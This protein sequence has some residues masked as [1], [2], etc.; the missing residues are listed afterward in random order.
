MTNLSTL[1]GKVAL[2]TGGASVIGE[3]AAEV[4]A[5]HG[6]KVAGSDIQDELGHS[7]AKALGPS[8]SSYVHCAVTD[9]AQVRNAVSTA[10]RTYEAHVSGLNLFKDGG[11]TIQ[12]PSFRMFQHPEES[13]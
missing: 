9:E 10:V 8:S 5:G 3:C 1:E 6:A 12:S 4:I 13:S 11:F 2:I 7:L